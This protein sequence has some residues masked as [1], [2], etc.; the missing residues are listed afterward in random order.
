MKKELLFL[1]AAV[2]A[3][4]IGSCT[5]DGPMPENPDVDG[6]TI[7]GYVTVKIDAPQTRTDG[8]PTEPGLSA[9]SV[10]NSIT[11]VF[12]D[13]ADVIK[14]VKTPTIATGTTTQK[15][16]VE[17]GSYKL[18]ALINN[19]SSNSLIVGDNI[20]RVISVASAVEAE[21]G[22]SSGSFFMVNARHNGA[23][24]AGVDVTISTAHTEASPLN[25]AA[26]VD[27]LAVK[28]VDNNSSQDF[29][30]TIPAN[31]PVS[32]ANLHVEGFALLNINKQVCLIQEWGD[33]NTNGVTLTSGADILQTPLYAGGSALVKDQYYRNIS[34]YATITK[35]SGDVIAITDVAKD[36]NPSPFT[37]AVKYATENRPTII[38]NALN[39]TAGRGETTGV[40]YKVIAQNNFNAPVGTFYVYRNNFYSG[41]TALTDIE[42]A[43]SGVFASGE[44]SSLAAENLRAK[45]IK[46]YEDGVMY[47][48]YFIVDPNIT[49]QYDSQNYYGVFRNSVYR[50]AINGFSDIGDDVPGGG[51]V[52]PEEPG[53]P[54]N[55]P[56]DLNEA[57]IDVA[58]TINPWV[59][60]I[61]GI[62]F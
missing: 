7:Q 35:S 41:P 52:D 48:S 43:S 6:T 62:D 42:A 47:Y 1:A 19:P 13:N 31:F 32:V 4:L 16:T 58:V 25:A 3:I 28:I 17:V 39:L 27:R 49:Y 37:T 15:F 53:E 21:A 5:K 22:L 36:I 10:I 18:Y 55:P 24:V 9:E 40:I 12:T 56:I 38:T 61:I 29:T 57:Y 50:L 2:A 8:T 33:E 54:G 23:A 51:K 20:Q 34:E 11:I 14:Y 30:P 44:L 60:N 26:S 46:V 45:D 59:L